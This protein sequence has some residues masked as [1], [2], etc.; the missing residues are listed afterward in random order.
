MRCFF[1]CLCSPSDLEGRTANEGRLYFLHRPTSLHF[2][3]AGSPLFGWDQ[4]E[5]NIGFHAWK[6]QSMQ[7]IPETSEFIISSSQKCVILAP[8]H[9]DLWR[10]SCFWCFPGFHFNQTQLRQELINPFVRT[11]KQNEAPFSYNYLF[12][13]TPECYCITLAEDVTHLRNTWALLFHS[14]LLQR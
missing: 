10:Q 6:I 13:A 4:L 1:Q 9:W 14:E 3:T 11:T 8:Q 5:T 2:E 7:T 12:L